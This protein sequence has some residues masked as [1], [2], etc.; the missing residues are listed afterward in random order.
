[1]SD[2]LRLN[3]RTQKWQADEHCIR[4]QRGG[5][6]YCVWVNGNPRAAQALNDRL[7]N[8][9]TKPYK[10]TETILDKAEDLFTD[11]FIKMYRY[12]DEKKSPSLYRGTPEPSWNHNNSRRAFLCCESSEN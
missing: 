10:A 6:E 2:N 8:Q 7:G 4:V 5:K 12:I 9:V 3:L 11:G 1:M